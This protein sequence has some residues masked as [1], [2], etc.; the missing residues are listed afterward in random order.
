[1]SNASLKCADECPGP[2]LCQDGVCEC[3][4]RYGLTGAAC[5]Q[6]TAR[7][8]LH[9]T[10]RTLSLAIFLAAGLHTALVLTK[11]TGYHRRRSRSILGACAPSRILCTLW[12][13]LAA[14]AF[15]CAHF[16]FSLAASLSDVEVPSAFRMLRV[17]EGEVLP[18]NRGPN[19]ISPQPT[20]ADLALTASIP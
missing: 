1:M 13:A 9:I 17:T 16:S 8:V 2:Q 4:W 5:D 18:C 11:A 15:G 3:F 7:A 10:G 12:S 14:S 19:S 6:W 20:Q